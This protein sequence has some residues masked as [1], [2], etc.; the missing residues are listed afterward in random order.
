MSQNSN[1]NNC[2]VVVATKTVHLTSTIMTNTTEIAM[3]TVMHMMNNS[4]DIAM[5][6]MMHMTRFNFDLRPITHS[7]HQKIRERL[8]QA[9]GP[10]TLNRTLARCWYQVAKQ[11]HCGAK[12]DGSAGWLTECQPPNGACM[13][14]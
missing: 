1:E 9:H 10:S 4:S 13:V 12:E 8:G 3:K 6:T 14:Y 2:A 7:S 11:G 5:K